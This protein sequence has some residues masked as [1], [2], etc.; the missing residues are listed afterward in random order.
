MHAPITVQ[1]RRTIWSEHRVN[2][3]FECGITLKEIVDQ[4]E[5]KP[6]EFETHGGV[7]LARRD[8][9]NG[10]Y[11]HRKHWHRIKPK[12]GMLIYVNR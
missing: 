9:A 12:A 4:F 11:I 10:C 7:Y 1:Y 6:L 2:R 8:G 5:D 3:G